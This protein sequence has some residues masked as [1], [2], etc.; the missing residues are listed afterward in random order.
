MNLTNSQ[1]IGFFSENLCTAKNEP[2][3]SAWAYYAFAHDL[4][5]VRS[6]LLRTI[7]S[8][9][10]ESKYDMLLFLYERYLTY[11]PDSD[12]SFLEELIEEYVYGSGTN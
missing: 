3:A 11:S 1:Y 5:Q 7:E 12:T 2:L 8:E 4:S 6:D 9:V 10:F